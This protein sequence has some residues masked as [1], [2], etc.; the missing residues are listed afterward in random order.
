VGESLVE[1]QGREQA[2]KQSRKERAYDRKDEDTEQKC[3]EAGEKVGQS[4]ECS[5]GGLAQ[6]EFDLLPHGLSP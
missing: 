2:A 1:A 3:E 6:G 4:E 5:V